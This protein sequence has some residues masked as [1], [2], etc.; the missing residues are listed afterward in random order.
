MRR[1][2]TGRVPDALWDKMSNWCL[3]CGGCNM[4]CPTCYCFSVK[5]R[6]LLLSA[7]CCPAPEISHFHALRV[8]QSAMTG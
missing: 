5:D 3:E 7:G 6:G 1:I 8:S 2:S 4:I